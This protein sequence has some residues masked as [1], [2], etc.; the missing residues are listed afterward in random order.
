[1]L[2]GIAEGEFFDRSIVAAYEIKRRYNHPELN[3]VNDKKLKWRGIKCIVPK[4]AHDSVN[5]DPA[6]HI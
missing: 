6:R 4:P 5:R 1:M 2:C 3:N